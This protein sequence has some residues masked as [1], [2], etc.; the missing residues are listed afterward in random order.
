VWIHF[1]VLIAA[2]LG[3]NSFRSDS[4]SLLEVL[5]GWMPLIAGVAGAIRPPDRRSVSN[6]LAV[7]VLAVVL[8]S[9]LDVGG[10]YQEVRRHAEAVLLEG[11]V[12]HKGRISGAVGESWIRITND[13]I[14][15][16][17]GNV[18]RHEGPYLTGDPRL[19]VVEALT[20][21]GLLLLCFATTGIVLGV[22]SWLGRHAQFDSK[23]NEAGARIA[24]A[25][26]VSAAVLFLAGSALGDQR[27]RILFGDAALWTLLT[28]YLGF[29][30]LGA[31]G[32][33]VAARSGSGDP[34]DHP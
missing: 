16:D 15:G 20:E 7:A 32:F 10:S 14:R 8:M 26:L 18:E 22:T 3:S 30:V 33:A 34:A 2:I 31:F 21:L 29:V 6:S 24:V 25:W 12:Q 1:G 9:A 23:A 28:P 17:L 19:K 4:G 13:W 11:Q 5:Y 27:F